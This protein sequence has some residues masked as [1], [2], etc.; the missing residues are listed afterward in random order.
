MTL[1]QL[2]YIIAIENYG[3]FVEAAEACGVTQSTMSL[4]VKKLEEE[5]DV[6]IFNRDTHPVSVTQI[7]RKVIDEAKL[8]VF[9][10]KQLTELTRSEKELCSGDLNVAMITSV[11][12]VLMA[13]MFKFMKLHYPD[14]RLQMEEMMT[15]TILAKLKKAEVD[16]GILTSPINDPDLLEIPLYHERFFAYV[17]PEDA[18][19][20]QDSIE[21]DHVLDHPVWI[22]RD[23]VRLFDRSMLEPGEAFTYEKMYEGGRVGILIQ[24]T[25]ENGGITIIPET[26][27]NLLTEPMRAC[28][29]PIV[30][31]EP[32]R[33][34]CLAFRKDYIHEQIMNIVVKSIKTII[35]YELWDDMI[36]AEHLKL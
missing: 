7:G 2:E 26:H 16:M 4:M 14:L 23:G 25:N 13:G 27:I 36:R 5:L 30:N 3:Y 15:S 18:M 33:T 11:A 32:K 28:M 29:K 21:K 17:S 8:V 6:R 1:Q 12:P 22:M 10:A 35:P 20:Q 34:I 24:I 31:P 9:H 19:M